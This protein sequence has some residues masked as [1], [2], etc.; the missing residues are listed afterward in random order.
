MVLEKGDFVKISYTG[1]VKESGEVFDTTS[2][3]IARKH[4]IYDEGLIFKSQ[5]IVIGA[6]HVL[7]GLDEALI[8]LEVG[9]E[10]KKVEVPPE[11]GYGLRDP[12]L[13]KVV[14]VKE[15]RRQG[16]TP[17]PGMRVEVEDKVGRIQSVGAGRV[18]VDFNHGLAGRTLDY[19]FTVEEKINKTSEKIRLLLERHFPYANPNDHEIQAKGNTVSITLADIAKLKNEALMGKHHVANDIFRFLEGIDS[20]NFTEVFKRPGAKKAKKKKVARKVAKKPAKKRAS[21]AKKK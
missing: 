1:R 9:E 15:F 7:R 20:V 21:K 8:G 14:P 3:K 10:K 2:E 18:R 12:K 19:D 13:V 16:I 17:M 5:P 4:D 6:G 11:K